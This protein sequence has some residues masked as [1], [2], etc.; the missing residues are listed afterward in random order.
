MNT[1]LWMVKNWKVV[2]GG[3]VVLAIGLAWLGIQREIDSLITYSVLVAIAAGVPLVPK[4]AWKAAASKAVKRGTPLTQEEKEY[5]RQHLF[6]KQNGKCAYCERRLPI[7]LF[8]VDHRTPMAQGG[9][10]AI[11]NLQLLCASCNHVKHNKTHKEYMAVV[12]EKGH[13]P[14]RRQR[15]IAGRKQRA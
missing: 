9:A 14:E 4:N 7:D 12:R 2:C 1:I 3:V 13:A 8:Q 10:N 15:A 6:P 11:T 5:A